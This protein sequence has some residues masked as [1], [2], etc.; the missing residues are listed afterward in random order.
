V[1]NSRWVAGPDCATAR[2]YGHFPREQNR[3][4]TMLILII[5]IIAVGY[6]VSLRIHPLRKCPRCNMSGRHFGAVFPGSYR[7][8]RKCQGRGQ[9]DRV[10]TQIFYGG[11]KGSGVFPNKK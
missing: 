2:G 8:C 6:L 3:S 7:R 1:V 9:L 5:V 10:G 4:S 11:T